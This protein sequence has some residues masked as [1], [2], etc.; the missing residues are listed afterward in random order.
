MN[1]GARALSEA[2]VDGGICRLAWTSINGRR[3]Y[4]LTGG[5]L[6]HY[7]RAC[8]G[9]ILRLKEMNRWHL[10]IYHTVVFDGQSFLRIEQ[11]Y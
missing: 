4:G 11:S 10:C 1:L 5:V 7:L 2:S 9:E 3:V 8:C 6:Q